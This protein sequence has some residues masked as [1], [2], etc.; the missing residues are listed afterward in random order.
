[1][2]NWMNFVSV[3]LLL[4]I[5]AHST[6]VMPSVE[7]DS[8]PMKCKECDIMMKTV[9]GLK[10]HIKLMHLRTGRQVHSSVSVI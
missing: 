8:F 2:R 7:V 1:M 3:T 6:G 9:K 5:P 4:P 10:M